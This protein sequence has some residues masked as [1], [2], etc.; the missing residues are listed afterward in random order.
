MKTADNKLLL[1]AFEVERL[2]YLIR[3]H[4]TSARFGSNPTGC[5]FLIFKHFTLFLRKNRASNKLT[6]VKNCV[7]VT[8]FSK[9][10]RFLFTMSL[11]NFK[12]Q[13]IH[14]MLYKWYKFRS[15]HR[16][17]AGQI[18]YGKLNNWESICIKTISENCWQ[19]MFIYIKHDLAV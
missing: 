9:K 15:N 10:T 12:F 14:Q 19:K 18:G 3:N 5:L 4:I 7:S 11:A 16:R 17:E 8:N 1:K 6:N 13:M 2:K